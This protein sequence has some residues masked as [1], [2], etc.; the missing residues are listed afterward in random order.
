M[1]NVRIDHAYLT[2]NGAHI[3]EKVEPVVDSSNSAGVIDNDA[4]AGLRRFDLQLMPLDL[5]GDQWR[6]IGL[7][8][9]CPDAHDDDPD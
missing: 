6:N 3:D 7:K 8:A 1:F 2:N 9:S 5:F 4:F